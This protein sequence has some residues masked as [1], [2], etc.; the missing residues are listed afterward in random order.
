MAKDLDELRAVWNELRLDS[1]DPATERRFFGRLLTAEEAGD[2]FERWVI[3]AFCLSGASGTYAF[4]VPLTTT[5]STREEIDGLIVDGGRAFLVESKCWTA[6]VDFAPI[7]LLHALLDLRPV[8]TMGL[9]FSAF[10]Y[11]KPAEEL[12]TLL[13]PHRVLL[14]YREDL[15]W[16]LPAAN[17]SKAKAAKEFQGRMIDVVRRKWMLAVQYSRPNIRV[18]TIQVLFNASE[19]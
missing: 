12:A 8:G 7:S 14:F 2:V 16:A 1:D 17:L 19:T 9:F 18:D 11:T 15:A 6:K 5:G 3:E 4:Q 10:G 13:R